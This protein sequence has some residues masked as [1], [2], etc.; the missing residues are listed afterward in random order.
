MVFFAYAQSALGGGDAAMTALANNARC[1]PG[2]VTLTADATSV[3]STIAEVALYNGRPALI[4]NT[5]TAPYTDRLTRRGRRP[6]QRDRG[7]PDALGAAT[8][9]TAINIAIVPN[10]PPSVSAIHLAT[11]DVFRHEAE[12]HCVWLDKT[13]DHRPFA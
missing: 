7:G 6:L 3:D 8:T 11:I 4:G 2:C 1:G 9:G 10:T 13:S 5:T 12:K